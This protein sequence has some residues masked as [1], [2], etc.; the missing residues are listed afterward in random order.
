L[1]Y[2]RLCLHVSCAFEWSVAI[3][4]AANS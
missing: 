2:A 1:K 4:Y 3:R